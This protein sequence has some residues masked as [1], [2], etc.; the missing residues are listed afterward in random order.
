MAW[1][2]R[3]GDVL[4]SLET[5]AGSIGRGRGL[6]G[7]DAIEGALL[8]KPAM[9]VH[10][11]GM[12]FPIDVVFVAPERGLLR[13]IAVRE[14]IRPFRFVRARARRNAGVGALELAEGEAHRL[15]LSPGTSLLLKRFL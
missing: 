8:L 5:A 1:L 3:D 15:G 14:T 2:L 11:L 12:R 7:R 13:V 6:L 4:C 9:S 10:T